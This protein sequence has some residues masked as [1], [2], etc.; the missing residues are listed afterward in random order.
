MKTQRRQ[1]EH[2]DEKER[3]ACRSCLE[4][5]RVKVGRFVGSYLPWRLEFHGLWIKSYKTLREALAD[6]VSEKWGDYLLVAPNGVKLGIDVGRM[7]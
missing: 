7:I 3:G 2:M 6:T 4:P 5:L 1:C